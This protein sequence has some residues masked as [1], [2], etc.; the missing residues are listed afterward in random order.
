MEERRRRNKNQQREQERET[1]RMGRW[2]R[3]ERKQI[4]FIRIKTENYWN[5]SPNVHSLCC[6]FLTLL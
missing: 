4:V 3:R 1:N 2:K 6:D 5:T